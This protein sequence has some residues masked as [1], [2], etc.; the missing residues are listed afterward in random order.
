MIKIEI[1]I[2]EEQNIKFKNIQASDLNIEVSELHLK[3][4]IAERKGRN[5][6]IEKLGFKDKVQVVNESS[7]KKIDKLINDLFSI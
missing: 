1:E 6:L 4:T 5:F 2:T 3:P 7:N